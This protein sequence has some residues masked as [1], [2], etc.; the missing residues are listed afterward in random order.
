MPPANLHVIG[1]DPG[2]TTGWC[3]L[4]VPRDCMYGDEPSTI[5]EWDYGEI[6]GGEFDQVA[7]I[8]RLVRET[9]GLDFG[10]GPAV[11]VEDF[12]I[13]PHA[14]TTDPVL[15][16][17]VRLAAMT[18]YACWRGEMGP[19]ATVTL[20]GR[21]MAKQTATDDR[22]HAWGLYIKGSDHI[23][24]ATRHA[25]VALRR[26]RGKREFRDQLWLSPTRPGAGR[27]KR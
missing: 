26:A 8:G 18:A 9:Q 19:D 16:W 4:T 12:D 14:P 10:V 17:P 13:P 22:L 21:T 11:V 15:L 23:R 7:A 24:D 5:I 2:E 1:I 27:K 3:R 20:Q 6:V 25:I